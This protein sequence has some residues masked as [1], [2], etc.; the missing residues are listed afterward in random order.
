MSVARILGRL[1]GAGLLITTA[2]IHLRL[3]SEGYSS[4]PKIGPLFLLN[5]IG[6]CLLAAAVLVTWGRLLR[7]AAAAGAL[8]EAGTL[9]GLYLSTVHGLF[10]FRESSRVDYYWMSVWVEVAGTIVLI[11][12]ALAGDRRW[13]PV[14]GQSSA[15]RAAM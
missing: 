8:L 3:Y 5:G 6:A 7:L 12:L 13:L 10:G 1:V 4:V 11:A 2:F 9:G 15:A 14:R